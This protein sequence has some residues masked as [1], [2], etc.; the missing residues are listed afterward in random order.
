MR[1]VTGEFFYASCIIRE[2]R[3]CV[4]SLSG[5]FLSLSLSRPK[6]R[7]PHRLQTCA[8]SRRSWSCAPRH[9]SPGPWTPCRRLSPSR[10]ALQRPC[11]CCR[12]YRCRRSNSAP[13]AGLI[14]VSGMGEGGNE[15]WRGAHN[16]GGASHI[17]ICKKRIYVAHQFVDVAC[18]VWRHRQPYCIYE[19]ACAF[20]CL[21]VRTPANPRFTVC[22]SA[23]EKYKTNPFR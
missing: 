6:H 16:I 11:R 19:C 17:H 14:T 3:L 22:A 12:G 18:R 10:R 20:A 4:G 13:D 9:P 5:L 2:R 8:P 1:R 15:S 21:S 23:R 7:S